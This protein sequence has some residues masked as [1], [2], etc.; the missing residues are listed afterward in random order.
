MLSQVYF[1]ILFTAEKFPLFRTDLVYLTYNLIIYMRFD[2][3]L[4]ILFYN[5][6]MTRF[7]NAS[8]RSFLYDVYSVTYTVHCQIKCVSV[9]KG[10]LVESWSPSA[11]I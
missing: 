10:I 5:L 3:M 8:S 1:N 6:P 11:S 7:N 9:K 4:L 2:I